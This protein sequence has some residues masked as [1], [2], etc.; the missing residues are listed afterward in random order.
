ML[1]QIDTAVLTLKELV[2]TNQLK[3]SSIKEFLQT[4]EEPENEPY[5][6]KSDFLSQLY[7]VVHSMQ[8]EKD[9]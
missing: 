9:S 8:N 4:M 3:K 5:V 6:Q 1:D 2:E 7:N